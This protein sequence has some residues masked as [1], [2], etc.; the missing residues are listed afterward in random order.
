MAYLN[1]IAYIAFIC[2][3]D[4]NSICSV[5]KYSVQKKYCTEQKLFIYDAP[6]LLFVG[7][8]ER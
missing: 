6:L 2:P 5:V 3:Y 7:H 8:T 4:I 1:N